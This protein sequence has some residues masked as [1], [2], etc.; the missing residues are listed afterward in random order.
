MKPYSGIFRLGKCIVIILHA[1][2]LFLIVQAL[3]AFAEN[4]TGKPAKAVDT[5][6]QRFVSIDFNNVDINVFIKFISE[7]TGKN[8]VVDH[9]V[10]GK[11]TIISPAKIS[12]AEAFKVF[13]SVLEVHGY[14]TVKAGEITKIVPSPDARSKNIRTL[15]EK[16]SGSSEDKIVT[17]LIHL[18]YAGPAEIKQLFTPLISKSS[19]ILAYPPTNTLIVTDVYS[20]IKRLQRIL[21]TID[22]PGIGHQVSVIPIEYADATKL[23]KTLQSVFQTTKKVKKGTTVKTIKF[24]ADER[25]N[26]IILLASE[27]DTMRVSGLIKLLDRETPRGQGSIHVYYLENAAAEDLAKVLQELPDKKNTTEKG[28]KTSVVSEKVKIR[29]DKATNS[30]IIMAEKEDYLVLEDIIKKLDIPRAM[31]YIEALIMEVNVDKDFRLGTEWAVGGEASYNGTDGVVGGG[32]SGGASG[33]DAGYD[34]S[35]LVTDFGVVPIPLPGGLSMGV[36]GEAIQIGQLIF[37]S[38]S[39]VIQAYK[40]DKDVHILSTPQILTTD[41][42]Q[43]SI[44]VGKNVPYQ[45]KSAAEGTTD[46]YSSY[47][48]KD[49]GKTLEITPQISKD[50]MIRLV[51]KLT[52]ET[53]ESTT[54]N[55]PTTLKRTMETTVLVKDKNTVVLGGLI[56]DTTSNIEYKV[57]CLGDIPLLE[58]M[59]KSKSQG[60]SKTN[61]YIFL[62]PK[63]IETEAEAKKVYED[64]MG[65][66]NK[67]TSGHIKMYDDKNTPP[68]LKINED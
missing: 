34:N 16:E 31:V 17:Q 21:K 44:T 36:M 54:D 40:K 43:A 3:P 45:T 46:T 12:L 64:K 14:T 23:S 29:A 60:G 28:K 57:P 35:G 24:V 18:K 53:L 19:V 55:R 4:A 47:E 1:I 33:G 48:Y 15:L 56:D 52:V 51:L 37:P 26:T 67:V 30:L 49:V 7:L 62:T 27:V 2:L 59:F 41:N 25:T 42:E 61:L 5:A 10:K 11:V 50:R 68:P 20:N 65:H 66:M 32:F 13:E 63:V 9:R 39:A 6:D 8:F 38:I 22:I 58:W